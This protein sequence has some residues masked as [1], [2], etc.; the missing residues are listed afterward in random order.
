MKFLPRIAVDGLGN[1][2]AVPEVSEIPTD[3]SRTIKSDP[4]VGKKKITNLYWDPVTQEI[5]VVTE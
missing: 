3:V 1:K 2:F 5:V 4:P